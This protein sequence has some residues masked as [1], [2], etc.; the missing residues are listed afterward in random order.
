MLLHPERLM[1]EP[2]L[3]VVMPTHNRYEYAAASIRSILS[4]AGT[5]IQLVVTDTSDNDD[6]CAFASMITDERLL[7]RRITEPLSMTGN[8]NAAMSLAT[9]K[10]ACLIGDD[11]TITMEALMATAWADANDIMI[12]SPLVVANYAWPDFRSKYLGASHAG[13]LYLR[14]GFG[15]L[16]FQNSRLNL[17]A[18]LRRGALGTEGLPKIYHGIVRKDLLDSIK[19]RSGAYFHGSSPDVS[20]AVSLAIVSDSYV[21]IDYPLTLPGASGKSNTGRSALKKHKGTLEGDAHTKRFKDLKWPAVLPGFTSVETV[22]AQSVCETL[23]AMEPAL[24][25]GYNFYEVYAACLL[26]HLDY[27]ERT[28]AAISELKQASSSSWPKTACLLISSLVHH[29]AVSAATLIRRASKPTAAGGRD[30]VDGLQDIHEAQ[31]RLSIE[32]DSRAISFEKAVATFTVRVSEA[33]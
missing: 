18:A 29:A 19:K 8:H 13:R 5:E 25:G 21:E 6:L 27:R 28:L 32:L 24:L 14:R 20:G 7:Y 10:Y 11:D 12:L 26:R 31:K 23:Q 9:G 3:S 4:I 1:A 17:E 16:S 30:F 15:R 22:W 33:G 2:L